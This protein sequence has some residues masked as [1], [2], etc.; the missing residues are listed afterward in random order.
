MEWTTSRHTTTYLQL[1]YD[2]LGALMVADKAGEV[3][4]TAAPTDH[5]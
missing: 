5:L 1:L 3:N 2:V 4:S